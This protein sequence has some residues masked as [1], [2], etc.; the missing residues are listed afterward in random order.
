MKNTLSNKT[1][2]RDWKLFI[3]LTFLFSFGYAIYGGVFL[4]FLQDSLHANELDLGRIESF[5]EVPGFLAAISAGILVSMAEHRMA[6]LGLLICAIGIAASGFQAT[7]TA[8]TLTVVFWSTGFHIYQTVSNAITLSLAKGQDGG[9]H[10]GKMR[11]VGSLATIGGLF[12]AFMGSLLMPKGMY[13]P[14][15]VAS[16]VVIGAA[17]VT[18][19]FISDHAHGGARQ[20]IVIKK[21]YSLYY[22]LSFLEGCRRMIFSIFASFTLILV[23]HQSLDAM[24][25][26]QFVNSIF[27]VATAPAIG[28]LIDRLGERRPL[29][30]YAIGLILVFFGYA[31]TRNLAA[32]YALF[33]IDNMLF[34]FGIGITTYLHR[35]AEK[36]DLTP[37][38]AMG[39]TTNHVAAV[40]V[41][42]F[43]ALLWLKLDNYQ[44]PFWVGVGVAT[45]SLIVTQFLPHGSRIAAN[46]QVSAMALEPETIG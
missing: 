25:A 11:M 1:L 41:P 33:I 15:F 37:S 43:G 40:T 34:S 29:T 14:Y 13:T 46:D 32:L 16:G 45:L 38:L 19:Y 4:N 42:Y 31:I 17:A 18:C 9:K 6:A 20:P 21:K 23:Y 3:A 27:I 30:W 2:E 8:L 24:L 44:A 36:K 5:R 22:L 28:K 12:I 35:V 39:V 10:L 7:I 26:V